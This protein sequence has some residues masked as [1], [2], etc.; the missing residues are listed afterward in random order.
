VS[1]AYLITVR[2]TLRIPDHRGQSIDIPRL[3]MDSEDE[4]LGYAIRLLTE[5]FGL[6]MHG[7]DAHVISTVIVLDCQD[8][9]ANAQTAT[10]YPIARC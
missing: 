9:H 7:F 4:A 6:P 1:P 3:Y 10:S 2:A 8:Q 5:C